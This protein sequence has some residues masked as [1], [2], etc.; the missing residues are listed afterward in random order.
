MT[1]KRKTKADIEA[2]RHAEEVTK[3]LRERCREMLS[4]LSRDAIL[5]QNNPV[6]TLMAFVLSERGRERS[7][8]LTHLKAIILYFADND[9]RESLIDF[10]KTQC[11]NTITQKIS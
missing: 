3:Q 2:A 8:E 1:I 11:P 10:L 4:T 5:R 7:P 6:E 9:G